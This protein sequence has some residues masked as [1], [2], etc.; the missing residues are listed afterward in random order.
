MLSLLFLL[1]C[2]IISAETVMPFDIQIK[3]TSIQY[4][5][6]ISAIV[7]INK[8]S[9]INFDDLISPLNEII[10][11]DENVIDESNTQIKYR[12]KIYP[13]ETGVFQVPA[14]TWGDFSS[15]PIEITVSPPVTANNR[16]I[17]VTL[18]KIKTSP[19]VREQT[20]ILF[21]VISREDNIILYRKNIIYKGI[22]S[23]LIPQSTSTFKKDGVV[24]YKHTIGWNVFFLHKQ[25]TLIS[26]PE[27]EYVINGVPK[28]KFHTNRINFS[29]KPLP[30]YISPIIPVGKIALTSSNLDDSPFF[31]KPSQTS[32]IQ[33]ELQGEGIP[34]KWL[35]SLSQRYNL[36]RQK[37]IQFSHI[38]STLENSIIDNQLTGIKRIDIAFTPLN[39]GFIPINTINLQ[40]FDP[41][42]GLLKTITHNHKNNIALNAFLQVTLILLLL[43]VIFKVIILLA[44]IVRNRI[45][46]YKHISDC[47]ESLRYST[48]TN[49]I[50]LALNHFSLA[51]CWPTNISINNWALRLESKYLLQENLDSIVNTIN[52]N[53]YSNLQDRDTGIEEL[54][55]KLLLILNSLREKPVSL[56][57]RFN[58]VFLSQK[59]F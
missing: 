7:T 2:D 34:A 15:K 37:D 43:F 55:V 27:L 18:T 11:Y 24:F 50:T 25:D 39:N 23:Y 53:L 3:K 51:Q 57:R 26:L 22:E 4:G 20:Q 32:I 44:H 36:N 31:M 28:Y 29:I 38:K 21:K 12:I 59:R 5:K 46:T 33:Y 1:R 41:E 8:S 47:K 42:L 45:I 49:D 30:I 16:K 13:N 6:Y 52:L 48:C 19:W 14:L 17:K 10:T 40:Y 56:Y 35:P 58:G 54:K 9:D